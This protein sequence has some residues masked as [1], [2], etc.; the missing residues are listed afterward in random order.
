MVKTVEPVNELLCA[1][2]LFLIQRQQNVGRK[3]INAFSV[4]VLNLQC[5]Y[6]K[7]STVIR[8]KMD[9]IFKGLKQ[10]L[11]TYVLSGLGLNYKYKEVESPL[12]YTHKTTND[13]Q[14]VILSIFYTTLHVFNIF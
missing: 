8:F 14:G 1:P 12:K 13:P 3:D 2:S 10:Q 4:L 9:Y 6:A 11:S 5:H 7:K